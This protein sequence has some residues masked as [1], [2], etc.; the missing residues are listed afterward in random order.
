VASEDGFKPTAGMIEEAKRGLAW[1]QKY[2]RG[3][4]LVGVARARDIVNGKRLSADTVRRMASFFSRHEVDKQGKGFTPGPNFPSPGR[5]AWALWGGDAGAAWSKQI[6]ERLAK[7]GNVA[8]MLELRYRG[9][10]IRRALLESRNCG[11]GAG[12]FQPGN[13]CAGGGGDDG[14][15]PMRDRRVRGLYD[16]SPGEPRMSRHKAKE[17]KDARDAQGREYPS[18][19]DTLADRQAWDDDIQDAELNPGYDPQDVVDDVIVE[20]F[21]DVDIEAGFSNGKFISQG[22]NPALQEWMDKKGFKGPPA[23]A[24][25]EIVRMAEAEAWERIKKDARDIAARKLRARTYR[26][27][28]G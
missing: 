17:G 8:T 25:E 13:N 26:R 11:T 21:G 15:R 12:G 5:I 20:R 7:R 23:K 22:A 14:A 1:R 24:M 9:F 10:C 3:G 18:T 27:P 19:V 16:H 4:T 28:I 6:A 2:D